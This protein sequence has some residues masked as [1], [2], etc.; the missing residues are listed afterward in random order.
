MEPKDQIVRSRAVA[1]FLN[2]KTKSS[3]TDCTEFEMNQ[4]DRVG[5]DHGKGI[6]EIISPTA[7]CP[8]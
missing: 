6:T 7:R 2:K 4:T 1:F 8:P 5:Q 3:N